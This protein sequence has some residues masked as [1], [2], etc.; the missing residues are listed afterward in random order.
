MVYLED[1]SKIMGAEPCNGTIAIQA[2]T[3][4]AVF[5][6]HPRIRITDNFTKVLHVDC[7]A[8]SSAMGQFAAKNINAV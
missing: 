4:V 6:N 1:A 2:R 5:H 7:I 3:I 8:N